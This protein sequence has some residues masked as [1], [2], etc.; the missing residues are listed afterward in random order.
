MFVV[1]LLDH[2][3]CALRLCADLRISCIFLFAVYSDKYMEPLKLS[4]ELAAIMGEPQV[5]C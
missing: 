4:P 3:A 2:L 5:S 1:L